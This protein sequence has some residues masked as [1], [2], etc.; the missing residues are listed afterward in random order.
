MPLS[1]SF[2][3]SSH[4]FIIHLMTILY[5]IAIFLSRIF[6]SLFDFFYYCMI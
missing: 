3:L 1:F 6:Y 5:T 4:N 2:F